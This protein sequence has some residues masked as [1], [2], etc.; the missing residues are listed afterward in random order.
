MKKACK[1]Y[2]NKLTKIKV[3]AKKLRYENE[4]KKHAN[5]PKKAWELLR[6]LFS[7][8][9]SKSATLSDSVNLNG[10]KIPYQPVIVEEFNEIFF[11]CREKFG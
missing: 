3:T 2:S 7:G 4:L 5:N 1:I 9:N 10:N 6:T 8:N 11:K